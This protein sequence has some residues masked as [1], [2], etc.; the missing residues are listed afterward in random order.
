[1]KEYVNTAG[2]NVAFQKLSVVIDI[3]EDACEN[4]MRPTRMSLCMQL[5]RAVARDFFNKSVF[6]YLSLF[7]INDSRCIEVSRYIKSYREIECLFEGIKVAPSGKC[8]LLEAIEKITN[9]VDSEVNLGRCVCIFLASV[10]ITGYSFNSI[11][12]TA[13]RDTRI[14]CVSLVGEIDILKRICKLTQGSFINF[15]P[16]DNLT[17][18]IL[19]DLHRSRISNLGIKI[20]SGHGS[21]S[22]GTFICSCHGRLH[23]GKHY[24]CSRCLSL[25]CNLDSFCTVC[26]CFIVSED[27]LN[28]LKHS[29]KYSFSIEPVQY[30]TCGICS[31]NEDCVMCAQCRFMFCQTCYENVSKYLN[32]CIRCGGSE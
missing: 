28:F 3:S 11:N 31:N 5:A 22:N 7:I 21:V 2:S 25:L 6:S 30:Q 8:V 4:D 26:S 20:R 15:G 18:L 23:D 32:R 13:A 16:T 1:M 29:L 14:N 17:P 24:K 9:Y 27:A 10:K 12:S 19:L